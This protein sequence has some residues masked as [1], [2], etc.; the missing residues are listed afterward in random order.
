MRKSSIDRWAAFTEGTGA[1]R[2]A[3]ARKT[4]RA[5]TWLHVGRGNPLEASTV[6]LS[7]GGLCVTSNQPL[8]PGQE[9]Q[10]ELDVHV[11]SDAPRRVLPSRVCHCAA[12]RTGEYRIGLRFTSLAMEDAQLILAM[13]A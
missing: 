13:L 8:S 6:D 10:V 2:R 9:C 7:Y 12:L 4:I 3:K 5:R 1:E 11:P